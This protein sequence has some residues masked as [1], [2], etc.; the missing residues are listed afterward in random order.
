MFDELNKFDNRKRDIYAILTR[1]AHQHFILPEVETDEKRMINSE[2]SI[3]SA[4]F[5]HLQYIREIY[6]NFKLRL[7]TTFKRH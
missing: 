5:F 7:L 6:Q 2:S 4:F 1:E 3:V